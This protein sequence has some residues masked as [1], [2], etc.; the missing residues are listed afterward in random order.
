METIFGPTKKIRTDTRLTALSLRFKGMR[1]SGTS[2]KRRCPQNVLHEIRI[3]EEGTA[4]ILLGC[5][6]CRE[7]LVLEEIDQLA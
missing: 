2:W 4:P 5:I 1:A 6:F 3:Q 7:S